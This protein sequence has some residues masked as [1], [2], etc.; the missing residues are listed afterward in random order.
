MDT[1]YNPRPASRPA[2]PYLH[3]NDL[4]PIAPPAIILPVATASA[5]MHPMYD[6][7][8]QALLHPTPVVDLMM[9]S[10][11][12]TW[13]FDGSRFG[14]P[15]RFAATPNRAYEG[16]SRMDGYAVTKHRYDS[17][18]HLREE[19]LFPREHIVD[20]ASLALAEKLRSLHAQN[21]RL[22]ADATPVYDPDYVP[23]GSDAGLFAAPWWGVDSLYMTSDDLLNEG[24]TLPMYRTGASRSN[25]VSSQGSLPGAHE[26]VAGVGV[27]ADC[28]PTSAEV[29]VQAAPELVQSIA[30]Q[31]EPM[32][33]AEDVPRITIDS[34]TGTD[35][36]ERDLKN[37][38]VAEA[39]DQLVD[40]VIE[41]SLA[42][43]MAN[44]CKLAA[45]VP[46]PAAAE[47]AETRPALL[48]PDR[49]DYDFVDALEV[50]E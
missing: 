19:Y 1:Y 48:S 10:K 20:E 41:S 28:V 7:E 13:S 27:Q 42:E 34:M 39:V 5:P 49:E 11:P 43:L 8:T 29:E 40:N 46:L 14:T 37:A 31:Y 36:M 32:D 44:E 30:T 23:D 2:S 47:D 50:V 26:L 3:T 35:E 6:E 12:L 21:I 16:V 17:N 9:Q 22:C 15:D 25:S 38:A 24:F 4:S 18:G 33:T 45:D